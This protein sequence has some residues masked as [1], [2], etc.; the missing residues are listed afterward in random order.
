MVCVPAPAADGVKPPA[1]V[2]PGPLYTPVPG[3]PLAT[4]AAATLTEELILP[5]TAGNDAYANFGRKLKVAG[6]V[7]F[8][9]QPLAV[10]T[11]NCIV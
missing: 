2:V 3:T 5:Q 1:A 7:I 11:L 6:T 9:V 10:V 4:D 8:L